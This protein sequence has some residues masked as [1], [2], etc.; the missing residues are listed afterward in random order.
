MIKA[1]SGHISCRNKRIQPAP[2]SFSFYNFAANTLAF[3]PLLSPQLFSPAFSSTFSS[4][5]SSLLYFTEF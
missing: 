5:F 1:G 3:F 4:A 2:C